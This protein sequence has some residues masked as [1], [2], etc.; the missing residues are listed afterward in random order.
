M[1]SCGTDQEN[2]TQ[3]AQI[4][5]VDFQA[6]LSCSKLAKDIVAG[7]F[8]T[9]QPREILLGK[10]LARKIRAVPG[11]EIIFF[12][13]AAD[14]SIASEILLVKGIF[15]S[16]DNLRD[17]ALAII[18]LADA[19]QLLVLEKQVHSHRLFLHNPMQAREVAEQL[20]RQQKMFE[21]T[22]WQTIFPQI[23]DI[24]KIWL[25]IQLFT[26]AIY[27]AAMA[28]ITFNTMYMS[29][30]ERMQEFAVMQAI[31]LTRRRLAVL[32]LLE[33]LIMATLSGLLG[34]FIGAS[35]NVLLFYYPIDLSHW[36]ESISW[37]GSSIQPMLFCVP[38]LLSNLLPLLSMILL[39]FAVSALPTWRL[40]RLKPVEA[41]REA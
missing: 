13:N 15:S 3:P 31:G 1:L 38:S 11:S 27:Y 37:G 29:F 34:L 23:A 8:L 7:G 32:I 22:P 19:Q 28:L 36:M 18:N 10:G 17:T 24:L 14:G 35:T 41:L 5:G 21:A 26:V 30:L 6:E 20:N 40:Y 12:S 2:H 4:V 9:G 25:G 39:G 33:S 16:G